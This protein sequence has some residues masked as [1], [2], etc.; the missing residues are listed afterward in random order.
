M[1]GVHFDPSII[2]ACQHCK[3]ELRS[4]INPNQIKPIEPQ[5]T[6]RSAS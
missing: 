2:D 1:S 3:E 5:S 6:L 4:A